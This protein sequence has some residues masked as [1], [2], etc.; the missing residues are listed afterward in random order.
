RRA[1]HFS[2]PMP[3]LIETTSQSEANDS[4][5]IIGARDHRGKLAANE[6]IDVAGHQDGL[7]DAR[8]HIRVEA[9]R[10]GMCRDGLIVKSAVPTGVDEAGKKLRVV[11]VT[12]GFAKEAYESSLRLPHVCLEIRIEFVRDGQVRIER[13]RPS[14]RGFRPGLTGF[15]DIDVLANHTVAATQLGPRR[16]E[17]RI[18]SQAVLVQPA[19][20][21]EAVLRACDL[22]RP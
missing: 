10:L 4:D 13:E 11:A 12:L 3:C 16:S 7:I 15:L 19:R 6:P 18:Q 14:E 22:V 20:P 8:G 2:E 17:A 21:R 9:A 1:A 5:A